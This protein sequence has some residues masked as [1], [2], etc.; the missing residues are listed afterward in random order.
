MK[1]FLTKIEFTGEY[2]EAFEKV[3][4]N[5][6]RESEKEIIHT[7]SYVNRHIAD[8]QAEQAMIIDKLPLVESVIASKKL[9]E[10]IEALQIEIDGAREQRDD[11][12]I[13]EHDIRS[14][15]RNA[16]YLMEHQN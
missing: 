10:K 11:L 9:E 5:K 12:E 2:L 1:K 3:L 7:S 14:Y 4:I 6:Y 15:I 13:K 16:R 8:L